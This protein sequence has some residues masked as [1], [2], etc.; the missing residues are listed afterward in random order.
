[1]KGNTIILIVGAVTICVV[2]LTAL[3]CGQTELAGVGFGAM[4]GVLAGHLNG[5][6]KEAGPNV[7]KAKGN[8]K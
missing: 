4:G 5:N 6:Q 3:F 7:G 1:M 2:T 8:T